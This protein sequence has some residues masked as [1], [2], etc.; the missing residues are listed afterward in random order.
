MIII[1]KF[2][3]DWKKILKFFLKDFR[4]KILDVIF[5]KG[6]EFE[7]YCLKWELLMGIFEMGWEKLF[8]I[9]EESI[10][11]VLFGRDILVRVKNGIGKSGVYFIFLFEWLD[12]KKDNI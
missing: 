5:I 7:D 1:I 6:N 8:F 10:F 11:I 3:D 4:I 12:L 9:Q 2:G